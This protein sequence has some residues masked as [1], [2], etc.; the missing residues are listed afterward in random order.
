MTATYDLITSNVLSA[1]ASSVTFS[2]I[3][4]TYRDLIV[5]TSGLSTS[6]EASLR[7]RF[8]SDTGNNYNEVAAYNITGIGSSNISS[9]A[10]LGIVP[11]SGGTQ[12][13]GSNIIQI[14]DY[15][16]TDKHKPV[17]SRAGYSAQVIMYAGRWANTSAITS[18]ELY[19]S[20]NQFASGSTF[21]L[22][23]IVS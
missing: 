11:D 8:N 23:G 9:F 15:S 21:Y 18:I 22:Y 13:R 5:V 16:T 17:L 14:I 3:P 19:P 7:M 12:G 1:N 2:T 20:A 6:A 10:N 4:S